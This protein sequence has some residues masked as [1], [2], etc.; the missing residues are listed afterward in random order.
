MDYIYSKHQQMWK[1]LEYK[2]NIRTFAPKIDDVNEHS[3]SIFK[4]SYFKNYTLFN[5][6]IIQKILL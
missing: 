5:N 2:K 3:M 6:K 1:P 4:I